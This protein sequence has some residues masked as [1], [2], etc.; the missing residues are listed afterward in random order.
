MNILFIAP[1][2]MRLNEPIKKVMEDLGH[3]VLYIEDIT[4]SFYPHYRRKGINSVLYKFFHIFRNLDSE[5]VKF[6]ENLINKYHLMD[7]HFDLLFCINGTS[8]HPYF[9]EK[10]KENNPNILKTLYIWDTNKYYNF[11]WYLKYFDRAFTFDKSDA[12]ELNIKYLPFYYVKNEQIC[13]DIKYDAFCIGS[14]HDGRLQILD[15]LSEQMD[16]MNLNYLFKVVYTPIKSTFFNQVVRLYKKIFDDK[17]SFIEREYKMGTKN[18]RF[19]TTKPYPIDEFNKLMSQSRV[20]ID[21]DRQSQVGLTPRLVWAIANGKS[22]ITTNENIAY[23]EYCPSDRIW[24]I[25][26]E[27]PIISNYMFEVDQKSNITTISIDQLEIYN[28]ITNFISS[29]NK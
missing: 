25:D 19:L 11:E 26:R 4:P 23:S 24:K 10:I 22:V 12:E 21:T 3:N 5:Y 28:W 29:E 13:E 15:K 9:F 6:W 27:N 7:M 8:L 2:Y 20:I 1:N 16:K 17:I 14:L 18:H